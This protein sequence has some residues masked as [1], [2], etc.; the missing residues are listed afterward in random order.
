MNR[1]SRLTILLLCIGMVG[2][3][4]G[5]DTTSGKRVMRNEFGINATGFVQQFVAFGNVT[6]ADQAPYD[7]FYKRFYNNQ[8]N[9]FR[10]GFGFNFRQFTANNIFRDMQRYDARIGIEQQKRLHKKVYGYYGLDYRFEYSLGYIHNMDFGTRSTTTDIGNG[11]AGIFGVEYRF[12]QRLKI[13]AEGALQAFVT[14]ETEALTTAFPPFPD[15][16]NKVSWSF[17]FIKPVYIFVSF[18]F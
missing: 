7:F 2:F 12:N 11:V 6:S 1:K 3:S 18:N 14:Q 4:Q 13:S 8:K 10:A 17:G 9:A 15:P 16:V 5:T